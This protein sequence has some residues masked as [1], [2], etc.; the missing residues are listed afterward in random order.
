MT[1]YAET[2]TDDD[3]WGAPT[4][5]SLFLAPFET[6]YVEVSPDSENPTKFEVSGIPAT[7]RPAHVA[8][9]LRHI[10]IFRH[11]DVL[12]WDAVAELPWGSLLRVTRD[13]AV[14]GAV[15]VPA[16]VPD[17]SHWTGSRCVGWFKP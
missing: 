17:P 5:Y 11:P 6:A 3:L 9:H 2:Q 1:T 12:L 7:V 15:Q 10:A 4:S 13:A 16:H 14:D 8:L